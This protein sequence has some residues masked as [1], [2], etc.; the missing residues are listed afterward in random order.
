MAAS[1]SGGQEYLVS[2]SDLMAGLIFVFIITLMV[3][4]IRLQM[5][6]DSLAGADDTRA[7][8]LVVLQGEL[9]KAGLD[10]EVVADQGI[11]RLTT[12]SVNFGFGRTDPIPEHLERVDLIGT[13]FL[14]VLPCFL[15]PPTD[16]S[17][18]QVGVERTRYAALLSTVLIE[19][20]TDAVPVGAGSRFRDNVELAGLRA[21]AVLRRLRDVHP[22][23]DSVLVRPG[24]L[25]EQVLSISGYGAQRLLPGIDPASDAHRRIDLRFLMEP[26]GANLGLVSTVGGELEGMR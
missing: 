24:E 2:V 15:R 25:R 4:A 26:P 18:E 7:Q 8:L 3:F 17:C 5:V 14:R 9:Q 13:V 11:L 10:V 12:N 6:R 16:P 19:G 21:A 20:H 23:V 22:E 1:D